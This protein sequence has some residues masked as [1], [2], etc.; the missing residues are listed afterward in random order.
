[1][2]AVSFTTGDFTLMKKQ[3]ISCLAC[4]LRVEL[5]SLIDSD[6]HLRNSIL[7]AEKLAIKKTAALKVNDFIK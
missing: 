1:M 2:A 4:E 7:R 3:L 6:P 5:Y